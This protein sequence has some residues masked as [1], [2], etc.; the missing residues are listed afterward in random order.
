MILDVI[1][2]ITNIEV[3]YWYEWKEYKE[4]GLITPR[5]N[6]KEYEYP[7]DFRFDSAEQ[8]VQFLTEFDPEREESKDWVLVKVTLEPLDLTTELLKGVM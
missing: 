8:A 6:P 7:I 5:S 3:E 2:N 4:D 1:T